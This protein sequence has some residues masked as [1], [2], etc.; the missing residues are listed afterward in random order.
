MSSKEKLL[1]DTHA[2]LA[3]FNRE[4]GSEIIKGH[5]D[6]IQNGDA[7]GF[8]ATIT[9]TELAY[10][11][12]RKSDAASARLRL[13]QIRH[14]KLNIISLTAEIAMDAGLTKR[15]GISVADAIIAASAR[16]VRAA[17]VTNDP[18]FLE[19]DVPVIRYP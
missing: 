4:Q 17:V 5:M 12:T 10:L 7:E 2:F 9:L 1:F 11:Y 19:L 16:A 8:V 15:P 13:M 3:F 6:A 14:S 18:H